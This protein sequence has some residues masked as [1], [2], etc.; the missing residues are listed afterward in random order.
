MA[1]LDLGAFVPTDE[2]GLAAI[3]DDSLDMLALWAD[4]WIRVD[5][6]GD[7]WLW[8][9]NRDRRGGY[10]IY[11]R[12]AKAHRI[13]FRLFFGDVPAGKDVLHRCDNPP[14]VRPSHL[15]AGTPAE[16][17]ADMVRK[18]RARFGGRVILPSGRAERG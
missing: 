18:G 8:R 11:G 5:R 7:C 2:D 12:K 4:F 15:W 10:G 17:S 13:A 16:N 14:C 9:G 3:S 6:T 1:G